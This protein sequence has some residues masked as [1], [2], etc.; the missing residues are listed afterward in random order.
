MKK[1]S[2]QAQRLT[3][4]RRLH[5]HAAI[6]ASM[7]KKIKDCNDVVRKRNQH[8]VLLKKRLN[9]RERH[10]AYVCRFPNNEVGKRRVIELCQIIERSSSMVGKKK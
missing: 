5:Y 8:I 1:L 7:E 6:V 4:V 2:L 10:R 9:E 3:V